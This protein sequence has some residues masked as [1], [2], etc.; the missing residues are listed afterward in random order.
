MAREHRANLQPS[1]PSSSSTGTSLHL[2]TNVPETCPCQVPTQ[3]VTAIESLPNVG[4]VALA[5]SQCTRRCKWIHPRVVSRFYIFSTQPTNISL[6]ADVTFTSTSGFSSFAMDTCGSEWTVVVG[7]PQPVRQ[8]PHSWRCPPT[9][10][11][12]C[13]V[14]PRP[15]HW[16]N[17]SWKSPQI[18]GKDQIKSQKWP[19]SHLVHLIIWAKALG[20]G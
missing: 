16:G 5:D 13:S 2:C 12:R 4:W 10:Q 19:Q 15:A 8:A 20:K 9:T 3:P 17:L 11:N 14:S 18:W 1:P 7:P 6:P